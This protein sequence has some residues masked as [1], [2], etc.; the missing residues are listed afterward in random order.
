RE[1]AELYRR[2]GQTTAAIAVLR[3]L[4][5]ANQL[6]DVE[7]LTL[8]K[9]QARTGDSEDAWAT[10]ERVQAKKPDDADAKVA[11]AEILLVK[12]DEVLAANLMDRL[13]KA[14]PQ[15]VSARLLRA[16]YFLTNGYPD[17]AEADLGQ[18]GP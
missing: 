11:E 12:G 2:L 5:D 18:I 10:L 14:N 16:K 17:M 1:R 13:L 8:A 4:R 7:L 3:D 6:T 9:L 15:L